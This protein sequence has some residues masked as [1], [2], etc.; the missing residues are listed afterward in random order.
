M[1]PWHRLTPRGRIVVLT[2]ALLAVFGAFLAQRDLF[3]L[4]AF[5]VCVVLGALILVSWPVRGLRHERRIPVASV[6]VGTA[7]QVQ[8]RVLGSAA[9]WPRLLRF[10]DVVPQSMGMRPRFAL[11]GGISVVG[12]EVTY[13]L[14]GAERGRFRIGPLLV[15]SLD[16]FGLARNDM[17]FATI[18][19]V[20]VTPHI[21]E[22][23]RLRAGASGASAE[24]HTARAGLV[25]QD[26]VLVREYRRGDDVRRVHWRSTARVGELMVRREEQSWQP[27]TRLV[28]DNR[29]SAHAGTGSASSFEWSVSAAASAGIALLGTGTT[30]ELADADGQSLGPD[31]DRAMRAQQLISEL[32]DVKLTRADSLAA[33]LAT[34]G[35]D[36]PQGSSVVA[37]LGRL[38]PGDLAI[39]VDSLPGSGSGHAMVLDVDT[40][41]GLPASTSQRQY[42]HELAEH[43]WSVVLVR[44]GTTVPNA[45]AQLH[46]AAEVLG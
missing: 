42:A 46:R 34:P 35:E 23:G 31:G 4:G 2:G 44:A 14:V 41:V 9:V 12:E 38:G 3:W 10:E 25:G 19:E 27:T 37:V 24:T 33:A 11:S 6:P 7:F 1:H 36:R 17:A 18:T 26:D 32:T 28:L 29:R 21:F 39:L 15:R 20:A 45:W 30:L 8:M 43:G 13:Q 5:A 40:F 22:L 16:P